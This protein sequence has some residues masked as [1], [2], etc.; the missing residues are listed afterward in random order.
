MDDGPVKRTE[1]DMTGNLPPNSTQFTGPIFG[2]ATPSLHY[3]RASVVVLEDRPSLRRRR[4]LM[5]GSL[6]LTNSLGVS[7]DGGRGGSQVSDCTRAPRVR[8]WS[9]ESDV[10]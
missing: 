8:F 3:S 1:R 10:S 4:R 9:S 5:D 7:R 6:M 2:S